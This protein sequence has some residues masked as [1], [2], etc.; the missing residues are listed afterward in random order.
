MYTQIM[1]KNPIINAL[2]ASAYIFIVA[3]IINIVSSTQKNKP[4]TFF[5]PVAFLSLLTFSATVMAFIFLYQPF[6]LFMDGKKKQAVDLFLKTVGIF[7]A[8]TMI[9]WILVISGLI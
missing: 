2:S 1:T 3:T 7:G 8:V 5:A 4:D 9:V 6:L